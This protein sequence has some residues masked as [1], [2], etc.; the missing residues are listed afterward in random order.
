MRN[1]SNPPV[2]ASAEAHAARI[3]ARDTKR[4]G[5]VEEGTDARQTHEIYA[6]RAL[7][8]ARADAAARERAAMNDRRA[9]GQWVPGDESL[10]D[11]EEET[12]EPPEF[13]AKDSPER[14]AAKVAH[15]GIVD[16]LHQSTLRYGQGL[17][18]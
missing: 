4:A 17:A 9:R 10:D 13:D 7:A 6:E 16:Q 5:T 2:G 15:R 8:G 11:T 18:L 1:P 3:R 14:R 12:E